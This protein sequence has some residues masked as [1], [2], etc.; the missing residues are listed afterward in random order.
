M[1][2][3]VGILKFFSRRGMN[4]V[5][6]IITF[7]R[8]MLILNV[9]KPDI[10]HN[11]TLKCVLY[12]SF[13]AQIVRIKSIVNSVAG[14]GFIFSSTKTLALIL[15]P[16]VQIF[17]K[18]ALKAGSVIFQNP[19][20]MS[21]L[22]SDGGVEFSCCSTVIMGSGVDTKVFCPSSF[23]PSSFNVLIATRLLW[24]KGIKEFVD[25]CKLINKHQ[26]NIS[27]M[28]AGKI[29][30]GNPSSVPEDDLKKWQN[31]PN[32]TFLGHVS[33]MPNLLSKVNLVVLPSSYGEGV[34]KILTEAAASGIPLITTD[35]PGCREIVK[36]GENGIFIPPKDANS[37]AEA[38]LHL[39]ND[40]HKCRN[41]SVKSRELALKH[42]DVREVNKRT[43]QV[44]QKAL[45][46]F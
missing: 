38:I 1:I 39:F 35:T 5:I 6:E 31:I 42:F 41:F 8:L 2:L 12:G 29:D 4:P 17:L 19:V 40:P 9:I 45:V 14:L 10:L 21:K 13:A 26:L 44:Y 20:D 43:L 27:F 25:A 28:I 23:Y 32:L 36:D 16:I 24:D 3:V 33:N 30:S 18:Q 46:N 37:L 22:L 15:K 11:F 7:I 34:P